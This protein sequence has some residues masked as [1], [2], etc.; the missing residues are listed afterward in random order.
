VAT[1]A[2]AALAVGLAAPAFVLE[3]RGGGPRPRLPF[4]IAG[5]GTSATIAFSSSLRAALLGGA[6]FGA[7]AGT[8]AVEVAFRRRRPD[9]SL[10]PLPGVTLAMLLV[11]AWA[12]AGLDLRHGALLAAAAATPWLGGGGRLAASLRTVAALGLATAAVLL[13]RAAAAARWQGWGPF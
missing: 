5:A 10:A 6:L 1:A 12:Y 7:L 9:A 8:W 4:V 3:P 2:G 13:A 11:G